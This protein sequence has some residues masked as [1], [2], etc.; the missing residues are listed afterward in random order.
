MNVNEQWV[1]ECRPTR[2]RHRTGLGTFIKDEFE[3]GVH[4]LVSQDGTSTFELFPAS[5]FQ[6]VPCIK[7]SSGGASRQRVSSVSTDAAYRAE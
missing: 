7:L 3:G 4:L 1:H 2:T 6:E 5:S